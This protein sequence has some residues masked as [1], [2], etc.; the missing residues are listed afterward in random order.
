MWENNENSKVNSKTNIRVNL[1]IKSEPY[2]VLLIKI[3][4]RHNTSNKNISLR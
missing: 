3:I 2:T 1:R 4:I